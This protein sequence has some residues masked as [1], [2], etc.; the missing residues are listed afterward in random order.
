MTEMI[1]VCLAGD[2]GVGKTSIVKHFLGDPTGYKS[3]RPT[4]AVEAN[5]SVQMQS[6]EGKLVNLSIWDTAGQEEF[7]NLVP[8]YFRNASVCII[9]ASYDN[10]ES[11][12]SIADW[13]DTIFQTCTTCKL[14]LVAN[15]CDL[16]PSSG[17][18][19]DFISDKGR[20]IAALDIFKTSAVTG[21]G[22]KDLFQYIVDCKDIEADQNYL[23]GL[24]DEDRKQL[25]IAQEPEND[26]KS[27]C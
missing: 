6:S 9:V 19:D 14:I 26:K 12:Q 4:V 7:R 23:N 1:K 11:F 15:K 24:N 20:S 8:L 18:T 5:P 3:A 13:Q 10:Y 25:D 17:I 27:C 2:S 16:K 22:I 21:E